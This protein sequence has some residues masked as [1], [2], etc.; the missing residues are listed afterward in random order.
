MAIWHDSLQHYAFML[1][2]TFY[3]P[4]YVYTTEIKLFSSS[5]FF[6]FAYRANSTDT[7]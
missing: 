5:S 1:Q 3:S 4:S 7:E 6:F 2:S